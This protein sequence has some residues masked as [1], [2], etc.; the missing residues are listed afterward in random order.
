MH[1]SNPLKTNP[2]NRRKSL[3]STLNG[4][5]H[6]DIIRAFKNRLLQCVFY[7]IW[8]RCTCLL[9][10]HVTLFLWFLFILTVSH[11]V[12]CVWLKHSSNKVLWL[13]G[14]GVGSVACRRLYIPCRT[15][16][17]WSNHSHRFDSRGVYGR[18][19]N[20]DLLT[21]CHFTRCMACRAVRCSRDSVGLWMRVNLTTPHTS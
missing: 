17:V 2:Q 1:Q 15:E 6:S 21:Y 16:F 20:F 3:K 13:W 9:F 12:N 5:R 19:K 8:L 14:L 4:I 10:P 11:F 7:P 18:W